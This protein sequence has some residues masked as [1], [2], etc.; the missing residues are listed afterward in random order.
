MWEFRIW[1]WD[2]E[3]VSREVVLNRLKGWLGVSREGEWEEVEGGEG[4]LW[5]KLNLMEVKVWWR[6][7]GDVREFV[8]GIIGGQEGGCDEGKEGNNK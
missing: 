6:E 4:T 2:L 8:R 1:G 3:G 5:E 7:V